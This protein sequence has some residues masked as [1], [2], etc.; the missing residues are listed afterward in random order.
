MGMDRA[1]DDV[2]AQ[3]LNAL[4]LSEDTIGGLIVEGRA[5]LVPVSPIPSAG[6]AFRWSARTA[7]RPRESKRAS[8]PLRLASHPVVRRRQFTAPP[9]F[10]AK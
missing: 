6:P 4:V 9:R 2:S 5:R 3:G 1:L 8:H 7:C 10:Q